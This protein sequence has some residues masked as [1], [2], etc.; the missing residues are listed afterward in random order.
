M[1]KIGVLAL[2]GAFAEH[3]NIFTNLGYSTIQVRTINDLK[4]VDSIVIPGGES[5]VIG[6]QLKMSGMIKPLKQMIKEGMPTWGTC[7]GLILLSDDVDKQKQ[8]SQEIIGGLPIKTVRNYYGRQNESFQAEILLE[9]GNAQTAVFIRA[10]YIEHTDK[11]VQ[12]LATYNGS[13]VAVQSGNLLGTCFHPELS[14]NNYWH[15]HFLKL[16]K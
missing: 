14:D 11:Q 2:Q 3:M 8:N 9:N 6:M 5:T 15:K 12:I 1:P 10:P 13:A 7:A 16:L 4:N